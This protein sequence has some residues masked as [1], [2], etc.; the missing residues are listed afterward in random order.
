MRLPIATLTVVAFCCAGPMPAGEPVSRKGGPALQ[1]GAVCSSPNSV[2][3]FRELRYYLGRHGLPAEYT[4]YSNYDALGKALLAGQVDIAWNSPLAHG[5]FT[6]MAGGS[7]ALVMRDV[8]ENYRVNLIVRKDAQVAAL[9]D[10]AGKT[11][12][13]GSCDSADATVLPVYF[14]R[15]EGVNFDKIKIVSLHNEVDAKGCPCHSQHHVLKA[16]Q[17]GRGQAGIISQEL[18]NSLQKKDPETAAKF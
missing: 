6:M 1:L 4:L 12:V 3:V 13:F 5:K 17:E 2:T 9:G 11:M 18:W 7:Q 16:L 10:L 8:D 15:K 14:L